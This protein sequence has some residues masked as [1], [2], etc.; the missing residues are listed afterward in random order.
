MAL[1]NSRDR[2][3]VAHLDATVTSSMTKPQASE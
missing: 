1:A 2:R 3:F